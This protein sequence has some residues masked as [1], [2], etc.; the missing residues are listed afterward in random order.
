MSHLALSDLSASHSSRADVA[1]ILNHIEN[2]SPIL[3]GTMVQPVEGVLAGVLNKNEIRL[4][5][6]FV[7]ALGRI[8]RNRV[9][10]ETKK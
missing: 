9:S 8:T 7:T 10:Y 6:N 2:V 5:R 3:Q 4:T 1:S